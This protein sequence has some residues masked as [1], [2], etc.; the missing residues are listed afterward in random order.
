MN[1]WSRHRGPFS[2]FLVR[3]GKKNLKGEWL[4]GSIG[5]AEVEEEAR[6]FLTDPRDKVLRVHVWSD[7][8]N[9]FVM[10]YRKEEKAA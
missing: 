7:T 4:K 9:Q 5:G 3:P 2:L 10:T 1:F 8:E 6:T